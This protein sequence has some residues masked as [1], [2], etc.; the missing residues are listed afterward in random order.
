MTYSQ[1]KDEAL[2]LADKMAYELNLTDEQYEAAYEINLDYLMAVNDY[3]A[4]GGEGVHQICLV[5]VHI[6]VGD[7]LV[8]RLDANGVFHASCRIISLIIKVR[9]TTRRKGGLGLFGVK[10]IKN[11]PTIPKTKYFFSPRKKISP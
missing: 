7:E 2:F 4:L 8:E 6:A 9:E 10:L 1:A 11:L 5:H 3:N